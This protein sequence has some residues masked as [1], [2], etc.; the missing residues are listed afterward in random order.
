[1]KVISTFA[2]VAAL[3]TG[4]ATPKPPPLP[5]REHPASADAAAAP[6]R[7]A[8]SVL[9]QPDLVSSPDNAANAAGPS[10]DP[11]HA[12]GHAGHSDAPSKQAETKLA[13]A[14]YVCPMHPEVTSNEIGKCPKCGMKL[15]EK[16]HGG[17]NGH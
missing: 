7:E 3:S 6:V 1:M 2:L 5:G 4:C 12:A 10:P 15:V 17:N 13:A 8:S 9:S 16:Q 11:S 14:A